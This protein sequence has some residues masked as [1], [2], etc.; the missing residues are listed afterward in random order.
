MKFNYGG[1]KDTSILPLNFLYNCV[2]RKA[3]SLILNELWSLTHISTLT[4]LYWVKMV[5][6]L[7]E[8]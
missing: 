5:W 1:S 2:N 6:D 7:H 3:F 4:A 8:I